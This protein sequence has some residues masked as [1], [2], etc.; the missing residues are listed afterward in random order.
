MTLQ[1]SPSR[2]LTAPSTFLLNPPPLTPLAFSLINWTILHLNWTL[3][4]HLIPLLLAP[5]LWPLLTT[6]LIR[7][8][9]QEHVGYINICHIRM[10]TPNTTIRQQTSLN[11]GAG[12][13][14]RSIQSMEGHYISEDGI[15]Q[16][17]L[18]AMKMVDGQHT[19]ENLSQ[20]VLKVIQDNGITSRL[21][22]LQMDNVSNNDSLIRVLSVGMALLY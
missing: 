18:L 1:W 14:Q 15:L 4:I 12:I 17:C 5:L 21:G 3:L 8:S 16:E 7:S 19:G 13:A 11:G 22:Y 6:Q 20:Y 2:L 10:S 9:D